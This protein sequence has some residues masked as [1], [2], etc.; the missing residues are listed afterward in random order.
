[1]TTRAARPAGKSSEPSLVYVTDAA[2][3]PLW[4]ASFDG[5]RF[6]PRE[7]SWSRVPIVPT[8]AWIESGNRAPPA[9]RSDDR[10]GSPLAARTSS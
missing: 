10:S 5:T 4:R 1:V 8:R 3:R 7:G 2:T 6:R 9:R